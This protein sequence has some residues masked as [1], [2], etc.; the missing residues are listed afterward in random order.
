MSTD[1]IGPYSPTT[2]YGQLTSPFT[3]K[4]VT[5]NAHTPF[6]KAEEEQVKAFSRDYFEGKP[7]AKMKYELPEV[8]DI[9]IKYSP[10]NSVNSDD[11]TGKSSVGA[12]DSK[13]ESTTPSV[14]A[15]SASQASSKDIVQSSLKR[16][17]SPEE[18]VALKNLMASYERAAILTDNPTGVLS[19]CSYRV[20]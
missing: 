13:D 5:I 16:G 18:A 3:P 10:S 19:T 9:S 6:D 11:T 15:F 1:A 17:Y 14:T 2:I 12:S 20:S 4:N 8:G 7:L